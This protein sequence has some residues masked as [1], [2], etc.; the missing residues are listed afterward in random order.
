MTTTAAT[1]KRC[2]H[3]EVLVELHVGWAWQR[4][5]G[6]GI[7]LHNQFLRVGEEDGP[8]VEFPGSGVD[9]RQNLR[10]FVFCTSCRVLWKTTE[11]ALPRCPKWCRIP[12][13]KAVDEWWANYEPRPTSMGSEWRRA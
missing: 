6:S 9:P 8:R 10:V 13:Q 2:T 7:R 11:N 5:D 1:P 4:Y 3:P 12:A